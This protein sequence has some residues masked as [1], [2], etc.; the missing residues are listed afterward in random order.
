MR[1]EKEQ[2]IL[3]I[4]FGI[5]IPILLLS[6]SFATGSVFMK[7]RIRAE[8]MGSTRTAIISPTLGI[9]ILPKAGTLLTIQKPDE[10]EGE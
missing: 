4:F 2:R 5:T 10:L 8:I 6:L 9:T 3:N 7:Q 1:P